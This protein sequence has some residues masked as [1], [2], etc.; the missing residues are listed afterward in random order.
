MAFFYSGAVESEISSICGLIAKMIDL[1]SFSCRISDEEL[2]DLRL[3]LSELMIN[4]CEHGNLNNRKKRVFF[5][6]SVAG[7]QVKLLVSDEGRGFNMEEAD[8]DKGYMSCSGRGLRIVSKLVD[9]MSI[10]DNIVSCILKLD[11]SEE[12]RKRQ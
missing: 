9:N 5:N 4:S 10:K 6:L 7:Q 8:L 1:I 11:K 3:I 2:M 12:A